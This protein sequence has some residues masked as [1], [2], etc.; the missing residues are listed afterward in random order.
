MHGVNNKN[1]QT[2]LGGLLKNQ[3]KDLVLDL[4]L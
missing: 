3:K 2:Y 4:I 1:V